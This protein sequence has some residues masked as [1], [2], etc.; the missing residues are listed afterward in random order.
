MPE[1]VLD[2]IRAFYGLLFTTPDGYCQF[3]HKTVQDYLAARYIVEKGLFSPTKAKVWD[4]RFAYCACLTHDATQA[5]CCALRRSHFIEAVRECL[6]NNAFFDP[7]TV[8]SAVFEH[9]DN[10]RENFTL[11]RTESPPIYNMS[12][13]SDFF[14]LA[15]DVF[16][17]AIVSR[18]HTAR[19]VT[20][21]SAVLGICIS[22]Y[23]RRGLAFSP[24]DVNLIKRNFGSLNATLNVWRSGR[25]HRFILTEVIRA[26]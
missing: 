23:V 9:F 18:A 14:D 2:E 20:G 5:L 3:V 12:Y 19:S 26:E 21:T 8:G 10:F 11:V 6:V 15:D 1:R 13:K 7:H 17:R 25:E 24:E 16:L 4:L 22:E